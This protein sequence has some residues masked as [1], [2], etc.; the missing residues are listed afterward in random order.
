MH[1]KKKWVRFILWVLGIILAFE[2]GLRPFGYGRYVIYRPDERLLWVPVPGHNKLTVVNHL[3]DN[4]NAQ[5]FRYKEDLEPKKSGQLRIFTFGDSVTDGWG[6]A[7]DQTYSS[8]LE[9]LLNSSSCPRHIFQV[10]D[11]GVNAYSNSLAADRLKAVINDNYDPDVV[12]LA[13]S[14]NTSFE[15]YDYLQGQERQKMLRR[16]ALKSWARR[17]AIYNFLIEDLLRDLVYYRARRL[18]I[19]G[20]WKTQKSA[21]DMD[22]APYKVKLNDAWQLCQR[23]NIPMVILMLGSLDQRTDLDQYQ[24]TLLDFARDH[25]L[26]LV[27]MMDVLRSKDQEPYYMDHVHPTP[28][29]HELIAGE[30]YKVVR[31]LVSDCNQ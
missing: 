30:L 31:P 25:Q 28:I 27:N 12:I 10:V 19:Q 21:P 13:Y 14:F 11:A 23:H 7:D 16:V 5:G 15:Q 22:P 2:L 9:K 8:V 17:S 4:I 18:L 1:R 3:P 20:S 6:V 29:G 24:V 26:P